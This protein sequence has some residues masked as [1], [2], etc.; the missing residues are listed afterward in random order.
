MIPLFI[1][2]SYIS[3]GNSENARLGRRKEE[4]E[5]RQRRWWRR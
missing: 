3:S 5:R 1:A 2:I 4:E